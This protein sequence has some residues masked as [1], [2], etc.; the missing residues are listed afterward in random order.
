MD[1]RFDSGGDEDRYSE[2]SMAKSPPPIILKTRVPTVAQ[3]AAALG[4]STDEMTRLVD[5]M[6]ALAFEQRVPPGRPK[7]F[8]SRS[9]TIPHGSALVASSERKALVAALDR[10][11]KAVSRKPVGSG[12]RLPGHTVFAPEGTNI[13]SSPRKRQPKAEGA[14]YAKPGDY[15]FVRPKKGVGTSRLGSR[16]VSNPPAKTH[17]PTETREQIQRLKKRLHVLRQQGQETP[18]DLVSKLQRKLDGLVRSLRHQSDD[19]GRETARVETRSDRR[20]K[21]SHA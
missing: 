13:R 15:V 1:T 5:E 4:V 7:P 21:K 3:A 2:S 9:K 16:D 10:T 19:A 17:E 12:V 14:G 18:P 8:N 6:R 20:A 11:Q